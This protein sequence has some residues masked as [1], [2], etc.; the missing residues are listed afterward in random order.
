MS[1]GRHGDSIGGLDT[2]TRQPRHLRE[3]RTGAFVGLLGWRHPK[4][5]ASTTVILPR[6]LVHER[7]ALVKDGLSQLL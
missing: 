1:A 3:I 5:P 4:M 6:T 7:H 2:R